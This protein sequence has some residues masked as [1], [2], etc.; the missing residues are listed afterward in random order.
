MHFLLTTDLSPIVIREY[1]DNPHVVHDVTAKLDSII[2]AQLPMSVW[3]EPQDPILLEDRW[4]LN[5]D[6]AV[7]PGED[8]FKQAFNKMKIRAYAVAKRVCHKTHA[9]TCRKGDVGKYKC[10]LAYPRACFNQATTMLQIVLVKDPSTGKL[11]PKA[12]VEMETEKE[13]LDLLLKWKDERIVILEVQRPGRYP[14][15]LHHQ[16]QFGEEQTKYWVDVAQSEN[17]CVVSFSPS[18]TASLGCNTNVESLGNLSQAKAATYCLFLFRNQV[19]L[20]AELYLIDLVKYLTKDGNKIVNILSLLNAAFLEVSR[21]PSIAQDTGSSERMST[22]LLQRFLNKMTGHVEIAGQM[23][24]LALLRFPSAVYSHEFWYVHIRPALTTVL[25]VHRSQADQIVEYTAGSR[26]EYHPVQWESNELDDEIFF[27][28]ELQVGFKQ[29]HDGLDDEDEESSR[30]IVRAANGFVVTTTQ[31]EHYKYRSPALEFMSLYVYAGIIVVVPKA[32]PSQ[33]STN[34]SATSSHHV[35][36][37][38]SQS[39]NNRTGRKANATFDF[40]PRHSLFATHTQRLRSK[41]LIPILAGAPPPRHPGPKRADASWQQ[42]ADR[43][44]A[45][46]LTLHMPW[47]LELGAPKYKLS[48]ETLERWSHDLS[49]SRNFLSLAT[50]FW[51]RILA[52]GL[53]VSAKTVFATSQYRSRFAKRWG[54]IDHASFDAEEGSKR[55]EEEEDSSL[56][57]TVLNDM[58][59]VYANMAPTADKTIAVLNAERVIEDLAIMD[60]SLA[61]PKSIPPELPGRHDIVSSVEIE[62]IYA[63]WARR[64][65][66]FSEENSSVTTSRVSTAPFG[67]D[68]SINHIAI[69]R[70]PVPHFK[71]AQNTALLRCIDWFTQDAAHSA[72]PQCPAPNALYLHISGA[73]GTGKTT[74]VKELDDRLGGST[75]RSV[76]CVAPTGIA[77]SGLPRGMTIHAAFSIAIASEGRAKESTT[78]GSALVA[79][80]RFDKARILVIDEVSMVNASLLVGIDARLRDWFDGNLPFGGLAVILMGDFFQ[81][82]AVMGSLLNVASASQAGLIFGQF[83]RL[84]F[85]DQCRAADDPEHSTRLEFF[86]NP[87]LSNKPVIASK[88]LDHLNMLMTDDLTQDVEWIDAPVIVSENLTRHYV[89]KAQAIRDAVRTGQPVLTWR[90]VLDPRSQSL[91]ERAARVHDIPVDRL[92]D[93]FPETSSFF[94]TGARVMLRDNI[95]TEK[96]ISNGTTC[97]LHS[98]SFDPSLG[99]SAIDN[100]FLRISQAAPGSIVELKYV[101]YSVNVKLN[102]NIQSW[103]SLETL[104]STHVVIPLILNK[105]RPREFKTM[106]RQ[107]QVNK[108]SKML[109]YYDFGFELAYA[110]TYHKVQGQTF[111][112]V[113]LDLNSSVLT[114]P[115]FYV[116]LSRV[117]HGNDIRILP[118][119]PE[120]RKRLLGLKFSSALDRWWRVECND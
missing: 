54:S 11:V 6:S 82:P 3:S 58:I 64:A 78:K 2:C 27:D 61:V 114:L 119:A 51:I 74:F 107:A 86:R 7:E 44:A 90:N 102:E 106:G 20:K 21:R 60:A 72:D 45:Y 118:I 16:E 108:K 73:A 31:E 80:N 13:E 32:N 76:V 52:Q 19:L 18:L 15:E 112:K 89:N 23:A 46:M 50:L 63:S 105:K 87:N 62:N 111:S 88:I 42:A 9:A 98:I 116:G 55:N 81:L 57:T 83:D 115:A 69:S 117:R 17:E 26:E 92:L 25:G 94:V 71:A 93:R 12:L 103:N 104:D 24:T 67:R 47:D 59:A 77:A 14:D 28:D 96:S 10:R 84:D 53:T 49:V 91:F 85:N 29:T 75:S 109:A 70:S 30:E 66:E 4:R 95:M 37:N 36:S 34:N 113:I 8:E 97:H 43:F 79:R 39:T 5:V 101:P 48:Y 41:H 68:A 35:D 1:L 38:S 110:I 65:P 100:E 56:A 22:H 99:R 33:D 40:D 120:T